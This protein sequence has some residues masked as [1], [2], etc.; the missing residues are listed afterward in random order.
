MLFLA[1]YAM[2]ILFPAIVKLL[3]FKVYILSL[4]SDRR[5]WF[6]GS[7]S[8]FSSITSGTF[9]LYRQDSHAEGASISTLYIIELA[10]CPVSVVPFHKAARHW[11]L[12]I[13]TMYCV[14]LWKCTC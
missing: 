12:F 9:F 4:I 8:G 11:E 14:V 6:I 7:I 3:S 1:I 2:A 10:Q 13:H 5:G